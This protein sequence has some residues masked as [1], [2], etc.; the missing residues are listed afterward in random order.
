[1]AAYQD[2]CH[3]TV[4][5]ICSGVACVHSLDDGVC[6]RHRVFQKSPMRA[7]VLACTPV[8]MLILPYDYLC[9]EQG[10]QVGVLF[11]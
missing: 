1:M 11:V 9:V 7:L 3:V 6:Q 10:L 8:P 2:V 4:S 5:H